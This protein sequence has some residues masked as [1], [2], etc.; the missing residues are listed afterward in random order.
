MTGKHY[1][2]RL[3][4]RTPLF[5]ELRSKALAGAAASTCEGGEDSMTALA[6][7]GEDSAPC[8]TP[9][10]KR[11][12][13]QSGPAPLYSDRAV[14]PAKAESR[15]VIVQMPTTA[16]AA[17]ENAPSAHAPGVS[18]DDVRVLVLARG[19]TLWVDQD[20]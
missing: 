11:K 20:S 14:S 5:D 10:A 18:G 6:F 2:A 3:L 16:P 8:H 17:A 7:E 4:K 9:V 15:P 12:R 13:C 1:S 19:K